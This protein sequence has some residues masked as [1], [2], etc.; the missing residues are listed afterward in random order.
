MRKKITSLAM[1][2]FA[3]LLCTGIC[4]IS[5]AEN[6]EPGFFELKARV[7]EIDLAY[8]RIVIAEKEMTI[9]S[10]FENNKTVWD[11]RFLDMK[12]HEISPDTIEPG[13]KVL[14][15]WEI[16]NDASIA[17]EITLLK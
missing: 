14:V 1:A 10:H 13:S 6:N 17:R 5:I 12:G 2:L 4:G 7:M 16:D 15:R 8:N 9:L 3:M 11:T